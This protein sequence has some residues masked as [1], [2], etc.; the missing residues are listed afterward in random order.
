M[1]AT[2]AIFRTVA[3]RSLMLAACFGIVF[4]VA[5]RSGAP[6]YLLGLAFGTALGLLNFRQLG[7]TLEKAINMPPSKAQ[8]YVSTHYFIRFTLVAIALFVSV[9]SPQIHVVGMV[10]GLM[11]VKLVIYMTQL[12]SDRRYFSNIFKRKEE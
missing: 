9:A 3:S 7:A 12:F 8:T 4:L 1:Q 5:F 11:T 6:P 2:Q 10:A